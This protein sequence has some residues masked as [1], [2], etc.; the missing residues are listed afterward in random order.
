MGLTVIARQAN[1]LNGIRHG[2]PLIQPQQGDV[3]VE[4]RKA[5]L[6]G[7]CSQHETGFGTHCSVAAVVFA[8]RHFYHEPHEAGNK[9]KTFQFSV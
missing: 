4:V 1:R 7:Y 6:V 5:E 3:I 9:M 2:H 8:E